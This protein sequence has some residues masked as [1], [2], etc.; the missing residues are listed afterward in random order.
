MKI[1]VGMSGSS[2][3][4]YGIRLLET[5]NQLPDVETELVMSPAAEL[6]IR[7]ETAW[8]P[9]KVKKLA[10]RTHDWRDVGATISSG[11]YKTDGMIV[12]PCSANSLASIAY[13]VNANNLLLRA[14]DVILKERRRLIIMFRETPL[15]RGHIRAMLEATE[16][17]AIVMPPVPSFYHHPKSIDEI[18][19]H[20]VARALD[21][22]GVEH[23]LSRRWA[24]LGAMLSEGKE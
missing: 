8:D 22:L 7:E 18:I 23:N 15:H 2:G 9:E 20:S 1:V 17:G 21:L 24:G 10:T 5:L 3:S 12:A 16:N 14:A 11:S 13:G 19:N 6:N 4:V